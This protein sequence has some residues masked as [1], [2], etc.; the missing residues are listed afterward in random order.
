MPLSDMLAA[1]RWWAVLMVLGVA[2]FP[3][4]YT[5]LHRLPDR[6]YAFLKMAGLLLVSYFF[7]LSGSLG[8]A[9][10]NSGGIFLAI[11]IVAGLSYLAYQR[12]GNSPPITQWARDNRRTILVTELVFAAVFF[13]WV[14]VRAQNPSITA[15]EKPMEFAFLNSIARS[16]TFPPLDPWLSGYAISYYYFGYVMTSLL[17]RLA[18][19]PE[20]MAFNLAVAWLVAGTATG[21]YGLAYNL[22]AS[23]GRKRQAMVWGMVAAAALPLAGNMQIGLELLHANNVGSATFWQWL[24]VRDINS[25]PLESETP[26]YLT[27]NWWWW[28]TSRV[29]HE[30]HLSGRSEEGLEP[31]VE[32]PSFSFVLGDLHPHVLA[33]P[34]AFLSLGV[35]LAW[36]FNLSERRREPDEQWPAT[37]WTQL[38]KRLLQEIGLP[39]WFFTAVI[40]G[41]LSFLNTWDVLIHLFII[42]G[43]YF[44]AGW[45]RQGTT[46]D[47]LSR[48]FLVGIMLII[49]A[50]LLYLPFY[51]GFRS[52]AAPPYL[53][54]MLM[55]PTRLIQ[56]LI[57]FGMPLVVI[58]IFL[59]SLAAR[60]QFQH[61]KSGV[62]LT[63]GFLATLLLLTILLL[64]IL[65][66]TS[67]GAG[68]ITTLANDLG[69]ALATRPD[70]SITPGWGAS[71]V[72]ALLPS[73]IGSRLASPWLI[74]FLAGLVVLVIM[75]LRSGVEERIA[76]PEGQE[77][78]IAIS[79]SL[80]FLLLLI[81]TGLLLTLGP[82]F[83]YLRDNFG[84][85]LN[86]TFKFYYQAWVMFGVAAVVAIDFLWASA[87]N[88]SRRFSA[89]TATALYGMALF[90]A[91][92][93]PVFAVQSRSIE[94]RGPLDSAERRPPTLDG[95]AYMQ[96]FNPSEYEAI[97]WLIGQAMESDS[98][99]PV[100]LEAV[101]GQYSGFARV[102]A[103]TG[104]PTVIGWPGHQ[105]QWRGSDHPEPG[106]RQS[107]VEQIYTSGDPEI[108]GFLLDQFNVNY[109]FVGDLEASTYGSVGLERLQDRL[110][111]AFANDH[112]TIYHWQP[113]ARQ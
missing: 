59:L 42:L 105:W 77:N 5:L 48:T 104:L 8:F 99:P 40:V 38:P 96:Y 12:R 1:V 28:R 95:M 54:P 86:T 81:L 50:I 110:E 80:P 43:A 3:L 47:L 55:R 56:Y 17:A 113:S 83:V 69:L 45:Y 70:G 101:G 15:T 91:L 94:Y 60:R 44:L 10:N 39:L 89:A 11:A 78:N 19:V 107:I 37:S 74:L 14:W 61:W 36:W 108:I 53:L 90:V 97:M 92:L 98:P 41:G 26:R 82:E 103:N 85:R 100:I 57:I 66:S 9:A 102:S 109:I 16:P 111:V 79:R 27:S 84:V 76:I 65:A 30:Y 75:A 87:R 22:I 2:A 34:F 112:V 67:A 23:S 46:R 93:F 51:L 7:W 31:I 32:V 52:Q 4:I 106:R 33:L 29:I 6:G 21:A 35:A 18:V 58:T 88:T 73:F 64:W 24:D 25:P 63:A 62:V 20:A 13:L 71:A 68:T 72:L 49:P